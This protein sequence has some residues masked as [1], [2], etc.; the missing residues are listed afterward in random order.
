MT[1][2]VRGN[3]HWEKSLHAE[4]KRKKGLMFKCLRS[5]SAV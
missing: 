1:Y 2:F 5:L 4:E 3:D